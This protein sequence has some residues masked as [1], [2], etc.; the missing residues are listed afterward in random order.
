[1]KIIDIFK[2]ES[3]DYYSIKQDDSFRIGNKFRK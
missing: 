2:K 1:L 3:T